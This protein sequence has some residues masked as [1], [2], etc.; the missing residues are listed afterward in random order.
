MAVSGWLVQR[1]GSA[2]A[3]NKGLIA[4]AVNIDYW[5]LSRWM[6]KIGCAAG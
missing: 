3:I 2:H 4:Y 6:L 1:T 5:Q